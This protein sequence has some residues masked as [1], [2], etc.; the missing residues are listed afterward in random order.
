MSSL[1]LI[2]P[3]SAAIGEN[4]ACIIA[5]EPLDIEI[6][7]EILEWEYYAET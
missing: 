7:D 5:L 6:D 3:L 4:E 1:D 2:L